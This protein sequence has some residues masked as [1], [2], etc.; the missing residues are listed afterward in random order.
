MTLYGIAFEHK[1][2]SV[3]GDAEKIRP[4]NPLVRV[5]TL[6]LGNGDVLIESHIIL[7]HLDSLVPAEQ[8]MFPGA[9]P[10]RHQAL[11]VSSL[12]MGLADKAV[13]LFYEK[14]LHDVTSDIWVDRCRGQI[15][16]V[17]QALETDRAKRTGPYWFGGK[18]G[19][20]DI[21]VA[22]AL[23]FVTDAHSGIVTMAAFPALRAHAE[24][25]EAVPVFQTI[26]QP[27]IPPS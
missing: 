20:A 5:P 22:V 4:F 23:R 10:A 3:F 27:F 16:G 21:A 18:I 9:E 11:K 14:R 8:R 26:S 24:M 13:S 17:V 15:G 6:V 12:A 7:D 25:L 1:P 19:H 2:W